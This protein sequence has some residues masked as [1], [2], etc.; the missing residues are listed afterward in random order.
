MIA[1][2]IRAGSKG[3]VLF[4]QQRLGYQGRVFTI[5]KFRTMTHQPRIPSTQTFPDDPEVTRVG[6]FLRKYKLDE[7]PQFINV[8]RGD[9][10]LIGPR[11]CLPELKEE[12]D[13][14][15]FARLKVRPGLFGLADI[16]GGYHLS[17][18][19]RWVHDREYVE[20]MSLALDLSLAIKILPVFFFDESFWLKR[21]SKK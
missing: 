19:Q 15:G 17:W 1:L 21:E 7:L 9:M 12:F 14:N 2:A 16:R 4:R 11:P 20:R 8:L 18:P 3:P 5:H 6:R 13:E 10:S